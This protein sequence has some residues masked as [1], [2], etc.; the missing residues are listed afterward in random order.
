MNSLIT[1]YRDNSITRYQ[2]IGISGY[3]DI[4][5]LHIELLRYNITTDLDIIITGYLDSLYLY[6]KLPSY[7]ITG[8]L[9]ISISGYI[10]IL[11]LY[12]QLHRHFVTGYLNNYVS[13]YIVPRE[14]QCPT[15][16][17]GRSKRKS[18][19]PDFFRLPCG[20]GLFLVYQWYTLPSRLMQSIN[21]KYTSRYTPV[22]KEWDYE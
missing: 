20:A 7:F 15:A 18:G 10:D 5:Y 2:A 8:Y 21:K 3:T 9:N 14:L 6:N 12:T 16:V 19:A 11:Y 13:R 17:S 22:I 4:M 1:L